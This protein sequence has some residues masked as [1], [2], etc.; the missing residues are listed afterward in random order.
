M[1]WIISV[2]KPIAII[3]T[4][5]LLTFYGKKII[6]ICLLIFNEDFTI[7]D[8]KILLIVFPISDYQLIEMKLLKF[9]VALLPLI[10]L[11]TAGGKLSKLMEI[12]MD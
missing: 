1:Q 3:P 5:K 11:A 10:E 12:A 7:A 6:S 2:Y 4:T 9:F 8:I